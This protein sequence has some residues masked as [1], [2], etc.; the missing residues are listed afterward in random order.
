M[1]MGV[2]RRQM[3]AQLA[4]ALVTFLL[5]LLLW[6]LTHSNGGVAAALGRGE[7]P[8]APSFALESLLGSGPIKLDTY[9]GRVI[10]V[11]FWASWCGPCHA[12][13]PALN[14][15]WQHWK[16]H[17]VTFIG[18]DTRDAKADGRSFAHGAH[19]SYPLGYDGSGRTART[20]GVGALPATF[21]ISPRGR[22][23]VRILGAVSAQKLS[24]A[25]ARTLQRAG[26]E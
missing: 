26:A 18:V 5:V 13:T 17:L 2:G 25:I 11:N 20:Y 21:V 4:V 1:S 12:E 3:G 10:V 7:T 8:V 16:S 23:V 19:I 14:R 15:A 9:G 22:V 6:M 24:A